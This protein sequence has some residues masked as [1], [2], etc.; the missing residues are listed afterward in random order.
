[1]HKMEKRL[2]ELQDAMAENN[3]ALMAGSD[4]SDFIEHLDLPTNLNN[5]LILT[6]N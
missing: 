3:S 2:T 4:L 5:K 1:M 6:F